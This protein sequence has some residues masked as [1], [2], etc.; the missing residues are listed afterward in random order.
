M[1]K[2]IGLIITMATEQASPDE[3]EERKSKYYNTLARWA[4]WAYI[5]E[6]GIEDMFEGVELLGVN[7]DKRFDKYL[8]LIVQSNDKNTSKTIDFTGIYKCFILRHNLGLAR[9][10][11]AADAV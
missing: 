10:E 11:L 1:K 8:K 5:K 4:F 9:V 6:K 7:N 2:E 3:I